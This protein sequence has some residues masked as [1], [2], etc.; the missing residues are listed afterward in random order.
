MPQPESFKI[1]I[2]QFGPFEA[3]IEKAW[4]AFCQ[5]SGL[6]MP[7][8]AVPMDLHPLYDS[9]IK[10][11]G[12]KRGRWDVAFINTD[13]ITEAVANQ[14]VESLMPWLAKSPP[15]GY[16]DAWPDSLMGMQTFDGQC[17]AL[18]L[19]DGPECLIYRKDLFESPEMQLGFE[20]KMGR[21]LTVPQTWDELREVAAFFHQ[22]EKGISGTVFAAYP[23]GHNTVFDFCLQLW[24]RNGQLTQPDG[25]VCLN[26]PEAIEGMKY[27]RQMLQATDL[28]HPKSMA[29]DSVKAGVAFAEGEIA[30]MVNWFGF[31][32]MCEVY[33]SSLVKGKVDVANVPAGPGGQGVSLNAYWMYVIGQ[34]S[35]QKDLA[36]D[37]IKFATNVEFDK[38]LT[39]EGGIGCRKS[40]WHD[41]E[42]NQKVPYYHKLEAL[43]ENTQALPRMAGWP[44]IASIIDEMVLQVINTDKSIKSILDHAQHQLEAMV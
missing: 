24:T 2:R 25:K 8:E 38:K 22:P 13:W 42:V 12:L 21:P 7:L 30:L 1:A 9:I 39:L 19:H 5:K 15:E 23:D 16:P 40:T 43:H 11:E 36:Y 6:D 3:A 4:N 29:F 34:G 18:P 28:I 35:Q 41:A 33:P 31:A 20:E 32:A 17:Y 10:E 27:Y 37:F 14:H 26:S 44:A